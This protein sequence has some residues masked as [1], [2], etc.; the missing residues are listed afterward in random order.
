MS[1]EIFRITCRGAEGHSEP[2]QAP[3]MEVFMKIF[4][5]FKPLTISAKNFNLDVCSRFASG[6]VLRNMIVV[7][8]FAKYYI[9]DVWQ[10]P[11]YTSCI[12]LFFFTHNFFQVSVRDEICSTSLSNFETL[13]IAV[14]GDILGRSSEILEQLQVRR[15]FGFLQQ[16]IFKTS[17]GVA[18]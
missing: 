14:G 4:S 13:M 3:K 18:A 16:V 17:Y 1:L 6:C 5:G 15:V 10:G 8:L 9:V 7:K 11:R 2:T 12:V